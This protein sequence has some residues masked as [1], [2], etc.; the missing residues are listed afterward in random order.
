MAKMDNALV[1]RLGILWTDEFVQGFVLTSVMRRKSKN[2]PSIFSMKRFF[3]ASA[4]AIRIYSGSS[5]FF[6]VTAS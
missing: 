4:F 5:C 3:H 1:Q 2:A 6:F